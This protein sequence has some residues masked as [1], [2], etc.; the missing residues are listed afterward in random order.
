MPHLADEMPLPLHRGMVGRTNPA[1]VLGWTA[2]EPQLCSWE[3]NRRSAPTSPEQHQDQLTPQS[4]SLQSKEANPFQVSPSSWAGLTG[5]R[6]KI[7][8]KPSL[9]RNQLLGLLL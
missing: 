3:G 5:D 6:E 2:M 7:Q 8:C 1:V 9:K 4:G